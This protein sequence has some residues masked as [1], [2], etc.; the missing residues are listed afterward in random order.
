[1]FKG[2]IPLAAAAREGVGVF[3]LYAIDAGVNG[4][5]WPPNSHGPL[6]YFTRLLLPFVGRSIDANFPVAHLN[7]AFF[8]L[9]A[10]GVLGLPRRTKYVGAGFS[11]VFGLVVDEI[12]PYLAVL[13]RGKI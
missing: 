13:A 2:P 11:P 8:A 3:W 12:F 9:I 1:M 7:A 10:W 5:I 4:A 6:A